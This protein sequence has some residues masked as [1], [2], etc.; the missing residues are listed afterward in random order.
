MQITTLISIIAAVVCIALFLWVY[1]G[2]LKRYARQ[3]LLC[4][5]ERAEQTFGAGTGKLKY[6]AVASK[7]Y[8]IMPAVFKFIFSEKAIAYMIEEAV[9]EMKEC[10][11]ITDSDKSG[12]ECAV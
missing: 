4:L 5:V 9:S 1:R 6:S 3:L 8:E 12:E 2:G 7:L 10:L 11:K